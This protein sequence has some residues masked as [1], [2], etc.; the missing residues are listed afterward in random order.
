MEDL[1]FF[2][3]A[4]SYI[5]SKAQRHAPEPEKAPIKLKETYRE[6]RPEP[7]AP[8]PEAEPEQKDYVINDKDFTITVLGNTYPIPTCFNKEMIYKRDKRTV[9]MAL[10]YLGFKDLTRYNTILRA[11]ETS[12]KAP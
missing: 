8:E 3:D 7:P 5:D 4:I 9:E 2:E 1:N 11:Q 10:I 12:E 6:A